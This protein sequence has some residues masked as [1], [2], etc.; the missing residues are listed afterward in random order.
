MTVLTEQERQDVHVALM[1]DGN[2]PGDVVKL[3]N[4]AVVNA[5]DDWCEANQASFNSAL[6]LP[7]RTSATP[8]Q[9]ARVL[10]RVAIRRSLA[11]GGS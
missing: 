7:F 3:D 2:C 5:I 4:R 11:L 10:A 1:R 8:L 9:K 6:P